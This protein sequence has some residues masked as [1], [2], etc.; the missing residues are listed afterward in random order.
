VAR[1]LLID[2]EACI[3]RPLQL[4]LERAGHEV[5][6]AANGMEAVRLWRE[7]SG[8]LVITDIQMPEKDGLETI[9]ELRQL[10]PLTPIIA[11]SGG[12]R[13]GRVDVLGDA[14][15][16]GAFRTI[17]KPFGLREMLQ[18]VEQLLQ[19]SGG[20]PQTQSPGG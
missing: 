18:A 7:S 16:L 10:S 2:D 11:M 17:S 12:H 13:D 3:R 5:F 6:T 9:L 8:D 14:T 20:V 19:A 1:I 15:Q 4:L